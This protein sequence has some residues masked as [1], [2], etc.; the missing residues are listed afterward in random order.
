MTPRFS[1]KNS[2]IEDDLILIF[3]NSHINDTHSQGYFIDKQT[4]NSCHERILIHRISSFFEPT[5]FS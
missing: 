2:H 3:K 4:A 5:I 1:V